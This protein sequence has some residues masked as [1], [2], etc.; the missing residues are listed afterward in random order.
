M[1]VQVL[2]T[3][4]LSSTL[5]VCDRVLF[6]FIVFVSDLFHAILKLIQIVP[7]QYFLNAMRCRVFFVKSLIDFA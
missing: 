4:G 6:V 3:H 5:D 1:L 2:R 7:V